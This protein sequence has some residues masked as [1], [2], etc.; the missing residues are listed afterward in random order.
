VSIQRAGL[1]YN[2][3]NVGVLDTTTNVFTTVAT[4]GAAGFGRGKYSGA[5]AV[6][7][8]KVYFFPLYFFRVTEKRGRGILL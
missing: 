1:P 8:D 3:N 4:T 5:A 2:Q 7:G 6:G